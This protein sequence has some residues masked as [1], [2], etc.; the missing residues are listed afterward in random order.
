MSASHEPLKA[1]PFELFALEIQAFLG[2]HRTASLATVDGLGVPHAANIQYAHED[3]G[4]LW[5]VSSPQSQHSQN[6]AANPQAAITVYAPNQVPEAIHGVQCRGRL[7]T[8]L[9]PGDSQ[10]AAALKHYL[11]T[12]A[13][14]GHPPFEAALAKQSLYCFKPS[15]LRWIDNRRGF[16]W[17]VEKTLA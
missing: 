12:F 1:K 3:H 11:A 9:A 10:Y 2:L 8:V 4:T 14:A 13:F 5:W 17:N 15:W 16:G 6:L 7:A